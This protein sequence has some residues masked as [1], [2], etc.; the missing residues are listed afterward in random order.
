MPWPDRQN[1]PFGF[2]ISVDQCDGL[3]LVVRYRGEAGNH[4]FY[5]ELSCLRALCIEDD[6]AK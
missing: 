6:L 3:T 5:G 4:S 2:Q 1:K